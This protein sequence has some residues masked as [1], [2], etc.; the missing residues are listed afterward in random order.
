MISRRTWIRRGLLALGLLWLPVRAFAKSVAIR[1]EKTPKLQ[2]TN[3]WMI[4][5]I[6][7]KNVMFIRDGEDSIRAFNPECTHQNCLVGYNPETGHIE[8]SCHKS[9]YDLE[10][11]VLS[12]PAPR[13]LTVYPAKLSE[14]RIIVTL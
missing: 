6:E 10:G 7:D 2:K 1:L 12:G 9:S 13:A 4:I 11:K 8:C 5:K 3:G 14:G